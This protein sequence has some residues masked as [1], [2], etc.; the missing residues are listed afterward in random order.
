MAPR[1]ARP[2]LLAVIGLVSLSLFFWAPSSFG[3]GTLYYRDP[4]SSRAASLAARLRE[5][6]TRYAATLKAREGLIKKHGPS[7]E[8]IESY[9]TTGS[10]TIWDFFIPSFQCP[11]HVERIGV[12]GDGGKWVCGMERIAKQEKCVIYSFGCS[13]QASTASH[14][15]EAA[16]LERAPGCEVWGYDFTVDSFGP[17]IEKI[18]NLKERAHFFP[19]ALGGRN[20]HGPEDSPKYYTL[21]ALMKLNGH[22]FIDVLKIDVEGAEFDT[23]TAFLATHKPLSPFSSTTLP[24]GQLQIEL[25][26]PFWTESNLVYVNYNAGG[27]PRLAEYSFMNIRG[28]HSLVYEAAD[29]ADV[30]G[31][32]TAVF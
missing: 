3:Y 25:H 2:L 22:A 15:F 5:E 19:W 23:L 20:A 1:T 4:Y 17:E 32:A 13:P 21:D 28:N 8:E 14:Q 26:A 10:Y 6:E 7:K 24:I 18:P 27:K 11:H 29:R 30:R 16:L 31:G 9:P 12:L